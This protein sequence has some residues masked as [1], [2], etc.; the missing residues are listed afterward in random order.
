MTSFIWDQ[1]LALTILPMDEEHKILIGLMNTLEERWTA[2]ADFQDLNDCMKRLTTFT[3]KHFSDEEEYMKT[4]GFPELSQHKALHS[5]MLSQL[6]SF[7]TQFEA[8]KTLDDK[9]FHFLQ[10]W[11]KGHIRGIDMKYSQH[12]HGTSKRMS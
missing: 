8:T 2:K 1:T 10:M 4:V 9:F 7:A 6:G 12:I 11:L 3:I 5:Q